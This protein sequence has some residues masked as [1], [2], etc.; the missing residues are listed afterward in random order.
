MQ[1]GDDWSVLCTGAVSLFP[2][3]AEDKRRFTSVD[4]ITSHKI[5]VTTRPEMYGIQSPR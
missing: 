4:W 1:E 5:T 3:V 2:S